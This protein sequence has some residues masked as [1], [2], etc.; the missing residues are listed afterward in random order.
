MFLNSSEH[1]FSKSNLIATI[2]IVC[3]LI[4]VFIG[5]SFFVAFVVNLAKSWGWLNNVSL[6]P[7]NLVV[8]FISYSLILIVLV[9]APYWLGKKNETFSQLAGKKEDLAFSGWLTWRHILLGIAGFIGSMILM[10]VLLEIVAMQFPEL[11]LYNQQ[12][13]G[14]S[15]RDLI[16]RKDSM[17]AFIMLVILAPVYE[18]LMFRGYL[19]SKLRKQANKWPA[20]II[21]SLLFGIAHWDLGAGLAAFSTAVLVT[22]SM[23]IVMCLLRES[24][25]SIYPAIITHM[26]KNGL[27]FYLLF[28]LGVSG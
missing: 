8:N 11:K 28:V 16:D 18:E 14:F 12:D 27:A 23:S 26:L 2:K 10:V 4:A 17:A 1:K 7:F 25:G 9:L 13:L 3:W 6:M 5:V 19:Y 21:T 15:A 24:T 20:I 22:F